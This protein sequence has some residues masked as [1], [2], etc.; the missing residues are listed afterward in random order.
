MSSAINDVVVQNITSKTDPDSL[1][2]W[3]AKYIQE[4]ND[5]SN[6]TD[7]NT[8]GKLNPLVVIK[9]IIIRELTQKIFVLAENSLDFRWRIIIRILASE[10]KM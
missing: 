9:L 1:I 3:T 8:G 2:V 10:N 5:K 4:N 6:N 7:Q